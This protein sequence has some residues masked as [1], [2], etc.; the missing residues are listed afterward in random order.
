VGDT[1]IE[2]EIKKKGGGTLD[3]S[4]K[5]RKRE[6]RLASKRGDTRESRSVVGEGRKWREEGDSL[7]STTRLSRTSRVTENGGYGNRKSAGRKRTRFEW[8]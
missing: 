7:S 8:R 3:E 2:S 6:T 5:E 1:E 4:Q